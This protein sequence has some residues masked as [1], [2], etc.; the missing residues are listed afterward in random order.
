MGV[1]GCVA[2]FIVRRHCLVFWG[3]IVISL[4]LGTGGVLLMTTPGFGQGKI[5][6]DAGEYD[7]LVTGAVTVDQ[8]DI[9]RLATEA[10]DTGDRRAR[11]L[12]VIQPL[13]EQ[14]EANY[15]TTF[16]F[17][18][19]DTESTDD[20]FTPAALQQICQVENVLLSAH[21]YGD[22]CFNDPD[23]SFKTEAAG[24]RCALPRLS[25]AS[26]FY[27]PWEST[28]T[29]ASE[30]GA[31]SA[32]GRRMAELYGGMPLSGGY[33]NMPL[34][35]STSFWSNGSH[36]RDCVLLDAQYV[37]ERAQWLYEVAQ[38]GDVAVRSAVGFYVAPG[39]LSL[40]Q[41]KNTRS[42]IPLG[43][44]ILD[45]DGVLVEPYKTG[46]HEAFAYAVRELLFDY[47]GMET[48]FMSSPWRK[49]AETADLEVRFLSTVMVSNEFNELMNSD[50]TMVIGS[51]FF[52]L[53]YM[54]F[55]T[56]SL[57]LGLLGM[58]MI[59][60]SL[61][62]AIFFYILLRVQYFA[63]IHV[64]AVF[65]VLGI[66]ADDIFVFADAWRQ[67]ASM[68]REIS[69]SLTRRMNFAYSRTAQAVFNTSFTTAVAFIATGVSPVMPVAA[70]GY[71]AAI[72]ILM[73]Y[74]LAV[75]FLPASFIIWEIYFRKARLVG[76]CFP[77]V[78]RCAL[79]PPE[80]PLGLAVDA[81]AAA[82]EGKVGMEEGKVGAEGKPPALT[83]GA[84]DQFAKL[85]RVERFF[86]KVYAP[87]LSYSMP[88]QSSNKWFKPLSVFLVLGLAVLGAVLAAQAMQ[89]TSPTVE[90]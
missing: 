45:K 3:A 49:K 74:V 68:D 89:L 41:T 40:N 76:C 35:S 66:G 11:R 80:T 8:M 10:T 22:V 14:A 23:A 61:P 63:M 73:N 55:H 88:R 26:L 44:P 31:M 33:T 1:S 56:G 32:S 57:S 53:L 72:A 75:T 20:M 7:W 84:P 5:F 81:P 36:T 24:Q 46:K 69:A 85:G 60:L 9:V 70:F 17:Y 34:A 87:A 51:L 67:S 30:A 21:G 2:S 65:I 4:G 13:T 38:L 29:A 62:L 52:V 50:F 28:V 71:Y 54:C 37:A 58:V 79:R 15:T 25:A 16:M 86:H 59:L 27:V 47:F 48:G 39:A 19:K 43:S 77:C 64:L 78:P 42:M 83:P 12:S 18:W 6:A 90:V 82:E